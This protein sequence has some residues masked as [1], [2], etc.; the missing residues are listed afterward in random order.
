MHLRQLT[1]ARIKTEVV[2]AMSFEAALAAFELACTNQHLDYTGRER[3]A[4]NS[5]INDLRTAIREHYRKGG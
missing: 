3:E 4:L 2:A 5:N 1:E